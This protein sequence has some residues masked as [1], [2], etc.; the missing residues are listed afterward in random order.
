[1]SFPRGHIMDSLNNVTDSLDSVIIETPSVFLN[2]EQSISPNYPESSDINRELTPDWVLY[3]SITFLLIL[4]WLRLIYTR[5]IVNVFKSAFNYQLALK[6]YNEPGII[7]KRI[8]SILN[9]FYFLTS[10]IFFYLVF[11]YFNYHPLGLKNLK[12]LGVIIAFMVSYSLFRIL[13]MKI[14]GELFQRQKLFSEAIFH[15]FLF[16]K[17]AGI[18]LIPFILL[19][20]YTR[21]IYQDV[22]VFTGLATFIAVIL[23]R[24]IRLIIFIYKSV[25]LLFYFILYLCTLEILPVL[26]IIKLIFSLSKGP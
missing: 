11:D 12:F 10:G 25:F 17:I 23:M 22:F 7:Q 3:F 21:D 18:I 1:M 16:N 4:A 8:F 13:L 20:A 9:I 24:F 19:I 6:V 2:E 5:F 14:T 26:V 15:N